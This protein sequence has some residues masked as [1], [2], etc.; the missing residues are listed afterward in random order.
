MVPFRSSFI[1]ILTVCSDTSVQ[2][3]RVNE[4]LIS[5]CTIL[6][7][8]SNKNWYLDWIELDGWGWGWGEGLD[9]RK[10]FVVMV[11]RKPHFFLT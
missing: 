7:R 1:F 4:L 6:I 3:F 9:E 8:F 5:D 10:V 2:R 11:S